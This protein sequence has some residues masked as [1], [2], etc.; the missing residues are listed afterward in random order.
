MIMAVLW[1][2]SKFRPG[3]I[4]T[5]AEIFIYV[6]VFTEPGYNGKYQNLFYVPTLVVN[7][8]FEITAC[9]FVFPFFSTV[10]L[11]SYLLQLFQY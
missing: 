9:Y 3:H 6:W 4:K 11:D 7:R 5:Y 10:P 1:S 8:I 2:L